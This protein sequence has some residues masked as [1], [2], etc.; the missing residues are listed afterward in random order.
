MQL[1][2][3]FHDRQSQSRTAGGFGMTLGLLW[4]VAAETAVESVLSDHSS[5]DLHGNGIS[6]TTFDSFL[7][8]VE[9]CV[10]K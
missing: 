5:A 3:V 6:K 2:R 7:N 10:I 4:S 1:Y 9:P 8:M